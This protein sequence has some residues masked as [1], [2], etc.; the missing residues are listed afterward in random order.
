[1]PLIH[2]MT[3][4]VLPCALSVTLIA[5]G[6]SDTDT[7]PA[8]NNSTPPMVTQAANVSQAGSTRLSLSWAAAIDDNTA[9]NALTYHIYVAEVSGGQNFTVPHATT[10]A[11]AISYILTGLTPETDYYVVVRAEDNAANED[12]NTLESLLV[13]TAAVVTLS[14]DV[15]LIFTDNCATSGCH[16]TL[17]PSVNPD[18]SS[19]NAQAA[20]VNVASIVCSDKRILITASDPGNSYLVHKVKGTPLCPTTSRMPIRNGNAPLSDSDILLIQN[21]VWDGALNN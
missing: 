5:C 14:G 15:Q 4:L 21:W 19:G 3:K 8:S 13:T 16:Q 9:S 17:S 10:A 2:N 11:G 7:P 20:L 6:G 1:M 18:L 12:S